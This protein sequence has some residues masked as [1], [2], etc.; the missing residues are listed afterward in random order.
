M[1][2]PRKKGSPGPAKKKEKTAGNT[3]RDKN[4]E[5]RHG[6]RGAQKEHCQGQVEKKGLGHCSARKK[7]CQGV[8]DRG[9][10]LKFRPDRTQP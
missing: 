10:K 1:K 7:K 3:Y 5:P 4:I 2:R 9:K 6:K 8:L